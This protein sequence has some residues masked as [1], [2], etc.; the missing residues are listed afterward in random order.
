MHTDYQELQFDAGLTAL[1]AGAVA[2]YASLLAGRLSFEFD[3]RGPSISLATACS[4][5]LVAVHLACQSLRAGEA[6]WALAAGVNLKL[7]PRTTCSSARS[8]CSR[9]DGRCKFGDANANG[10][11]PSDG[12]GVVVLKPLDHALEDGD[13]GPRGDPWE[14]GD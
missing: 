9:P 3:L 14:R 7:R 2:N 1:G 10:F 5:S 4:S 12:A 6:P 8:V 11:A 13:R